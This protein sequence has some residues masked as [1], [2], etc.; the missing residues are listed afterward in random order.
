MSAASDST[1][2]RSL[3]LDQLGDKPR[4]LVVVR[5]HMSGVLYSVPALRAI[6]RRWPDAELTLLTSSY[7]APILEGGSNYLD[8]ILP[9]Y[10]FADEPD[11][12]DR[13][14]DLFRKFRTW[15]A[16]VGRVDLVVHLRH[17]GPGTL[18]FCQLLGNPKQVGYS[19][20]PGVDHLLA[21]NVGKPD[22][23][24]G[25]RERNEIIIEAMGIDPQGDHIEM[26][27]ADED[28]RWAEDWLKRRGHE[29]GDHL[30]VVHPG[31]HWGCNQWL[32]ERW[33][34]TI[35]S[36]LAQFGGTV[37]ITGVRR[38]RP[39]AQ[40]IADGAD[41][42]V[43]VAAGDTS[44]G[45]FAAMIGLSDLVMAIDA[46]PTQI[47]QALRVP[48]VIMMGAGNPSWNGPV[49]S[50]PMVML[51]EWDNDDP[52]PELCKWADGACNS[53]LCTSRLE[54]ISVEQV[55]DSVEVV[56]KSSTS[57]D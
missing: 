50:E 19:Q 43:L 5:D 25:S 26:T 29:A 44:L 34:E 53:T 55:L 2:H 15:A 23:S 9:L 21:L 57:E 46:S 49:G 39:L 17:V 41:G 33:S 4:I 6:R 20:G 42:R 1:P 30:V 40:K 56:L 52:R 48:A 3:D 35:N 38:E 13:P 10:T 28:Q 45:Q 32:P 12:F 16:L 54:D 36:A 51:Q 22:N 11:R 31:S 7:S 18:R 14:R 24:L 47:C 27:I 37:V 8:R